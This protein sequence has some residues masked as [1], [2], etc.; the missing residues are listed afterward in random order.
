MLGQYG[1]NNKVFIQSNILHEAQTWIICYAKE[2]KD[3]KE[4]VLDDKETFA[5]ARDP[6]TENANSEAITK[7]VEKSRM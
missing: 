6:N 5:Y 4:E 7:A 1:Q 2:N 3:I